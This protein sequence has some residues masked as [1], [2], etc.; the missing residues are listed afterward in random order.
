MFLFFSV[1]EHV[2]VC[3]VGMRDVCI[4]LYFS[5]LYFSVSD[6]GCVWVWSLYFFI[7][8][9]VNMSVSFKLCRWGEGY[10]Y[11]SLFFCM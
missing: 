8:L 5:C 6:H 11:M 2:C 3:V 9:Y 1:C 4:C 10:L 7:F